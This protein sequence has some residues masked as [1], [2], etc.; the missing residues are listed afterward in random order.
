MLIKHT[1]FL[2]NRNLEITNI[3]I[4]KINGTKNVKAIVDITI[5]SVITIHGL[6]IINSYN[7]ELFVAMPC[8]QNV[9]RDYIDIITLDNC[10]QREINEIILTEYSKI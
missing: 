7:G 8:Y 5:N 9:Y 6:K 3:R 2:L 10:I 1:S 4:R